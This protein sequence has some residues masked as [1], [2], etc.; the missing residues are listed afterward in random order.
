MLSDIKGRLG[1]ELFQSRADVLLFVDK[2]IPFNSFFLFHDAI[3]LLE[4]LSSTHVER[5]D[6]LQ[7]WYQSSKVGV[8]EASARHMASFRLTLPTVFGRT[9][10]GSIIYQ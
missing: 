5:K 3:I 8:N 4:S 9:K 10:E 2:S 7:E 6:V 1:G